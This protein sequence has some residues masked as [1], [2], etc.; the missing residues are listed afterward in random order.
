MALFSAGKACYRMIPRFPA[1]LSCVCHDDIVA[2][3]VVAVMAR[4]HMEANTVNHQMF[5]RVKH[6]V[7][8][9]RD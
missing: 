2:V 6:G 3:C 8:G 7:E 9:E 5:S 1:L 4:E